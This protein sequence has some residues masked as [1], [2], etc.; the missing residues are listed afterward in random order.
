MPLTIGATDVLDSQV[1]ANR[2]EHVPQEPALRVLP[3]QLKRARREPLEE[4]IRRQ[5]LAKFRDNML[6]DPMSTQLGASFRGRFVETQR[7]GQP[8]F[9]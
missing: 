8:C 4:D 2:S 1:V 6:Q 7:S 5:A 3:I 9:P